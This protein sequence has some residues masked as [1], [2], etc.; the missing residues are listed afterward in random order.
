M[1]RLWWIGRLTYD[2]S[3]SDPYE[4]TRFLCQDQ[5]Y[6]ESICGRNVFN[7][8]IVGNATIA[9]LLIIVPIPIIF[10][11]AKADHSLW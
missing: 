8:P 9:A 5:D 4:L 10:H 6:I 2:S 1:A 7:N 11:H 3:R